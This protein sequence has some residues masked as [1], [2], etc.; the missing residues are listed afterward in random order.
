MRRRHTKFI[1]YSAGPCSRACG[2]LC[3]VLSLF[4]V[5]ASPAASQLVDSGTTDDS[6]TC[7]AV[8]VDGVNPEDSLNVR[9]GPG[10][11]FPVVATLEPGAPA[12]AT[13]LT[14]E[15]GSSTWYQLGVRDCEPVGWANSSFLRVDT[16]AVPVSPTT[17]V[18]VVDPTVG[19]EGSDGVTPSSTGE[20][21]TKPESGENV[22]LTPMAT[23]LLAFGILAMIAGLIMFVRGRGARNNEGPPPG[24]VGP[25]GGPYLLARLDTRESE[26]R[27]IQVGGLLKPDRRD[28][29]LPSEPIDEPL[30]AFP[31][32]PDLASEIENKADK[33]TRPAMR[34]FGTTSLGSG[35]VTE[36]EKGS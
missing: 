19:G 4:L 30:S 11:S 22:Q 5:L 32:V 7:V 18:N 8:F 16:S 23:A 2:V 24:M 20:T 26:P 17:E 34:L 15:V 27:T 35:N 33:R 28:T 9:E 25:P 13:G 10:V 21:E 1:G 6:L 29:T 14:S 12:V 3:V 36:D 31:S